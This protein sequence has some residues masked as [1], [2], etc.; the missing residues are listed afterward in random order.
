LLTTF[1]SLAAFNAGVAF[2]LGQQQ[3]T[4]L[5]DIDAYQVCHGKPSSIVAAGADSPISRSSLSRAS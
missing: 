2:L 4:R 5:M 1:V 3:K